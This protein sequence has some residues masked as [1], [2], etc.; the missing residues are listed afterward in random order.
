ML[1]RLINPLKS[2]KVRVAMTTVAVAVLAEYGFDVDEN[3]VFAIIG[4][5]TAIIL[6][7]AHE[8]HGAKSAKTS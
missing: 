2:R 3:I 8:D 6:G 1:K 4:V 5:G 7:I